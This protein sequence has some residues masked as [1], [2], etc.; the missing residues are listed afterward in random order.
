LLSLW[1]IRH[2]ISIYRFVL[3]YNTC[4]NRGVVGLVPLVFWLT[5][6]IQNGCTYD[7]S[8]W[9]CS[10]CIWN[11][12]LERAILSWMHPIGRIPYI[13]NVSPH[14]RSPSWKMRSM[15]FP[16]GICYIFESFLSRRFSIAVRRYFFIAITSPSLFLTKR[17]A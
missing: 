16:L 15:A 6:T 1:Y 7:S 2:I 10:T 13:G 12:Q 17:M 9:S 8:S 11:V 5:P 4:A 14:V 3:L